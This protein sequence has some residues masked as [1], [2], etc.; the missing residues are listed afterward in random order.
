MGW[1]YN[2]LGRYEQA[3]RH[4]QQALPIQREIKERAG[5]ANTLNNLMY[6]WKARNKPRLAIFY[7]KQSVNALQSIRGGI[8]GLDKETQRGFVRSRENAYRQLARPAHHSGR[9][10]EAQQVLGMLKEEE[11]FQFV[12]R[13]ATQAQADSR[14]TLNGQEEAWEKA[15]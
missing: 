5:E 10:A 3:S 11:F 7:G 4:Y 13:D 8:Q 6:L 9:L 15:L 14:A 12:R 2:S 1:A